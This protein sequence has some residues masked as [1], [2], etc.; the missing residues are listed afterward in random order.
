MTV[1]NQTGQPAQSKGSVLIA[2]VFLAIMCAVCVAFL[3]IGPN[4]DSPFSIYRSRAILNV[5]CVVG[6]VAF[7]AFS[8]LGFK[9][10]KKL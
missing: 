7:G 1:N 8:V 4:P 9:R 3:F 5:V 2:A 10:L 6:A